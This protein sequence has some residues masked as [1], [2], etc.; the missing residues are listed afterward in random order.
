MLPSGG[1]CDPGRARA[2]LW[3]KVPREEDVSAV[4]GLSKSG[5]SGSRV[6]WPRRSPSVDDIRAGQRSTVG[7]AAS[8]SEPCTEGAA[9]PRRGA[10]ACTVEAVAAGTWSCSPIE[11][12]RLDGLPTLPGRLRGRGPGSRALRM[13]VSETEM[14]D[15]CA[16]KYAWSCCERSLVRGCSCCSCCRGCRRRAA[17]STGVPPPR[18]R[19]GRSASPFRMNSEALKEA[20]PLMAEAIV[21]VDGG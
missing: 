12:P 3:R 4:P 6:I 11:L 15:S 18:L 21:S 16:V 2:G 14:P 19:H 10:C 17:L 9:L 13:S 5:V 1:S 7:T 20:A 8:S